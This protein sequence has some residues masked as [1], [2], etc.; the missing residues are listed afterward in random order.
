[1]M[2]SISWWVGAAV[3]LFWGVGAYN[4]LVRLRAEAN[5]A[6]AALDAQWQR[7][8]ALVDSSMPASMRPSQLTQPGELM[9]DVTLLWMALRG[10]AAQL[11]ASLAA[12]RSRPLQVDTAAALGAAQ[13]V[14]ATAWQRVQHD[15]HDLAG[16][17]LPDTVAAQWQ[18]LATETQKA[19]SAFNDAVARYNAAIAQFPAVLLAWLFG[20]QRAAAV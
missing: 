7:Q 10:A 12:M 17:S 15:A 13:D 3:L 14:L 19:R 5:N 16:A 9:D 1:M 20:F 6:F 4:R 11:S 18:Q 2:G 8:L